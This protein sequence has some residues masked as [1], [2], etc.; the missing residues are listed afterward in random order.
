MIDL[1]SDLKNKNQ[2]KA[3][4]AIDGPQLIVAGPGSG[5]TK[6]LIQ[7]YLNMIL[8][9]N[10]S[11]ENILLCTFTE[12]AADEMKIRA[13]KAF[14]K[15]NIPYDAQKVKIST[16]HSFCN[17]IIKEYLSNL[18]LDKQIIS[19]NYH[20][21]DE[22]EQIIYVFS[23]L[24]TLGVP[25]EEAFSKGWTLALDMCSLFNK[26][27][28]EQISPKELYE[29]FLNKDLKKK[30]KQKW[31]LKARS[32]EI[33]EKLLKKNNLIDFSHLQKMTLSIL[34]KNP[35]ILEA[36]QKQ[37]RYLMVDEFQ[38]T[39]YLQFKI[40]IL[41]S[42]KSKN[43]M[44]VGDDDQSIYGF[45]G[46]VVENILDF[47]RHIKD[48][49]EIDEMIPINIKKNYRSVPNIIEINQSLIKHNDIRLKKQN[50]S[51]RDFNIIDY[52]LW[53]HSANELQI[54]KLLTYFIKKLYSEGIIKNYSDIALLFRSVRNHALTIIEELRTC[55]V[56][57]DVI[58][59]NEFFEHKITLD[60][61]NLAYFLFGNDEN[62]TKRN[63]NLLDNFFIQFSDT[64]EFIL[65]SDKIKKFL[66]SYNVNDLECIGIINP[67]DLKKIEKL[68]K[69]NNRINE[70]NWDKKYKSMLAQIYDIFDV[71]DTLRKLVE[72][73][74]EGDYYE[75]NITS[76]I[77]Q[78]ISYFDN[79][80]NDRHLSIFLKFFH[81]IKRE[82]SIDIQKG[83]LDNAVIISTI[84]QAKGLEW[85]I[86]IVPSMVARQRKSPK[87]KILDK[88]IAKKRNTDVNRINK[89]YLSEERRIYYVA[90]TRAK[91]VLGFTTSEYLNDTPEKK[92][93]IL[94]FL[95]ELEPEIDKYF[96]ITSKQNIDT[97]IKLLKQKVKL[98]KSEDRIIEKP[99]YS[100]TQIKTYIQ[101]PRQFLLLRDLNLATVQFGQLTFG[102]NIHIILEHIHKYYVENNSIDRDIIDKIFNQ[103]WQSFGF[104]NPNIERKMKDIAK[105]YIDTYCA[106]YQDQFEKIYKHG[107]EMPFF[108]DLDVC[109]FQGVI[110]LVYYDNDT[111]FL[112]ILDFK[113]GIENIADDINMFQLQIYAMAYYKYKGKIVDKLYV[114]NISNNV[115][116]EIPVNE[117]IVN[118]TEELIKN[119]ATNMQNKEFPKKKGI[120]CQD[121]AYKK[122]CL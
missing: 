94:E 117:E 82:Q 118:K 33:Y 41:V 92:R 25:E 44:V 59:S 83:K 49:W 30:K 36:V 71:N 116:S 57:V 105:K 68:K 99:I 56:P 54:A 18:P 102:S 63:E 74:H 35:E 64:T 15:F 66:M 81:S 46:A 103:N 119:V 31:I 61:I 76:K 72:N 58:G 104:R 1:W 24:I 85:P 47:E 9:H 55:R 2:E 45:R 115:R 3:I 39:N 23:N 50:I 21:L 110:D 98:L 52:P 29:Y 12:K 90:F 67:K 65:K 95:M 121:C 6:V 107:I 16:I 113:A 106:S 20:V 70:K 109:Y 10:I 34:E 7:R 97:I 62:D 11:P 78:L 4:K 80:K 13:Y 88:L 120:H 96:K 5:K 79:F 53:F 91:F 37:I 28:D 114:H 32:F 14:D 60:L 73:L 42:S 84:H 26:C 48:N 43:L 69:I 51:I 122:F 38:D 111:D 89:L 112:E 40:L 17:F 108:I 93:E 22:N 100:Y 27:V 8:N 77:T 75:L 101:C 19:P 86:V 87:F